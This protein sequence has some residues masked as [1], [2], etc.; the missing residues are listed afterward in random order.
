MLSSHSFEKH[1]WEFVDKLVQT[2]SALSA[3]YIF[4]LIT[5]EATVLIEV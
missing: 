1:H 3:D 2:G 4:V 5:F